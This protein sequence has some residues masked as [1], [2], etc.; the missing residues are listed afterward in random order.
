MFLGPLVSEGKVVAILYGDNL[1]AGGPIGET[2][3]L[4]IFLDQAG[5]AMEKA[6]L[7]RRLRE[8]M[9]VRA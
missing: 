4:E 8:Q 7:Q 1:T 9:E 5:L 3:G 6:L 2:E